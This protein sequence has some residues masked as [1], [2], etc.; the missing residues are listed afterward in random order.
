MQNGWTEERRQRQRA[1]IQSWK[2]WLRST[3]PKSAEGNARVSRNAFKG[4][5][6]PRARA[7]A[8]EHSQMLGAQRDWLERLERGYG[9]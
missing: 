1:A 6:R 9:E 8:R 7:F 4:A 3:G 5:A 2:P